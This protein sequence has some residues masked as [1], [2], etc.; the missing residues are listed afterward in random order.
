VPFWNNG[1]FWLAVA[2]LL[3]GLIVYGLWRTGRV[4]RDR[5][6]SL[7]GPLLM[8]KTLRGRQ[9]IE[10]VARFRRGWNLFGDVGIVLAF[11]GMVSMF[12]LLVYGAVRASSIPASQAPSPASAL[13]IP[14][15]NPLLPLGYGLLA[16]VVGVVLH[17]LSHGVLARANGIRVKSLGVLFL[18][19]PLGAFVEQDEEDMN[20]ATR[21]RRDRVA[22]AGVMSNFVLAVIFFLALSAV[23]TTSVHPKASGV[24][25]AAVFPGSGAANATIAAGDILVS[26]NGSATP[27]SSALVAG[28]AHAHPGQTVTVGWYSQASQRLISAPVTLG[29]ATAYLSYERGN[30]S[31]E[32][33]AF[34]GISEYPLPPQVLSGVLGNPFTSNLEG[35]SLRGGFPSG[36]TGSLLFLA[37]PGTQMLPLDGT[38][39]QFYAVSGPMAVLG[40]PATF[41]VVNALYWLVWINFL[42][43]IFNALPAVPL[44]GSF[45]FRDIVGGTL[46][47]ARPKMP[48][49]QVDALVGGLSVLISFTVLLLIVWEFLGPYL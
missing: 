12:A 32:E 30:R 24:G 19:I 21:R 47:R 6:L 18:V 10:R 23:V 27:N 44:D 40:A 4:G 35:I 31:A 15:L 16:L 11:A 22:A 46:R 9:L 2:L 26:F 38:V 5:P 41:V 37:L 49:G 45:L 36:L 39:G 17:E 8:V 43:G 14:G 3:Y 20:G 28:L 29:A 7:L 1:Y 33:Q 34:L 42:L 48:Q 13:S 25:I